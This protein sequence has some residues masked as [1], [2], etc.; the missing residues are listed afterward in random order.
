MK[1]QTATI[2]SAFIFLIIALHFVATADFEPVEEVPDMLCEEIPLRY[3]G[4]FGFYIADICIGDFGIYESNTGGLIQSDYDRL[5]KPVVDSLYD[6][7]VHRGV[8]ITEREDSYA[9]RE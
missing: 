8:I 4:G 7:A 3:P 1:F 5:I 2:L 9:G 6:E